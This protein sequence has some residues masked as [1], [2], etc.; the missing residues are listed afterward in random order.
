MGLIVIQRLVLIAKDRLGSLL[1]V[2]LHVLLLLV[3]TLVVVPKRIT[4]EL[5]SLVILAV[6]VLLEFLLASIRSNKVREVYREAGGIGRCDKRERVNVK[7]G[8]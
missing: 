3:H 8:N 1:I 7:M 5:V 6:L 2:P 4:T